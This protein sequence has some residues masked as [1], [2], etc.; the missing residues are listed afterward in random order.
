MNT[1]ACQI[2]SFFRVETSKNNKY[3]CFEAINTLRLLR[4]TVVLLQLFVCSVSLD[5][6]VMML[7][8]ALSVHVLLQMTDLV[9]IRL[10]HCIAAS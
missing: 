3:M 10:L 5:C 7:C 1:Q 9:S 6:C 8:I 4:Q 2:Q